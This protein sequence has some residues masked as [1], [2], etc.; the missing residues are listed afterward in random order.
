MKL[1]R[2]GALG[3]ER[4]GLLDGEGR[5]RDLSAHVDD[6]ASAVLAPESLARLKMLDVASLPLVQ[7][8]VRIGAP[9]AKIGK[10]VAVGLNFSDHA[11]EA[12]L[13]LPKEPVLFFKAT[14]CVCG[15]YDDVP[16]PRRAIKMDW[17]VELGIVIGSVAAGVSKEDALSHIAGYCVVNDVSER[18]FQLECGTQWDKGKSFDNFCPLG[19]YMVTADEVGDAHELDMWLEVNGERMQDGNTRNMVIK[20]AEL[21]SYVS[22]VMTLY[23]GD[24]IT[25][26]T[27]AGVG[28]GKTPPRFLVEGDVV[29]L[30]I[31]KL[32]N[33]RQRIVRDPR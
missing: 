10:V 19:P 12:G 31:E 27:P 1:L 13:P 18:Y 6:I 32:G 2:Y 15:A 14:S 11:E 7:E 5:I 4:P 17:E 26:G 3:E 30:G 29:T 20:S 33:Q 16:K 22:D 8:G 23:P 9:V 24:V 21:V 25:T 28:L